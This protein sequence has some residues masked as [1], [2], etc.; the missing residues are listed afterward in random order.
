MQVRTAAEREVGQDLVDG[1]LGHAAG[2]HL[3]AFDFALRPDQLH[4]AADRAEEAGRVQR[5]GEVVRRTKPDGS[6]RFLDGRGPVEDDHRDVGVDGVDPRDQ[7]QAG[8][9]GQVAVDQ[10]DVW[11]ALLETT[12]AAVAVRDGIQSP[13]CV[14]DGGADGRD[15]LGVRIDHED[16]DRL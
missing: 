2:L 11:C 9:V 10:A 15:D 12:E 16:P 7:V 1:D 14:R 5:L 13:A 6:D 4:R 8:D 3:Q